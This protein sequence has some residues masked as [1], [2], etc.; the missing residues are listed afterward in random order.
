MSKSALIPSPLVTRSVMDACA[1][2]A[3]VAVTANASVKSPKAGSTSPLKFAVAS[4]L[5]ECATTA[6]A[7]LVR[8]MSA[9]L[10]T[11]T[12]PATEPP[13]TTLT[14]T[15]AGSNFTPRIV[16]SSCVTQLVSPGCAAPIR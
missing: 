12:W 7:T 10:L 4:R 9:R 15:V 11:L 6:T 16:N 13:S 2:A 8:A 3:L 5:G 14:A 1:G